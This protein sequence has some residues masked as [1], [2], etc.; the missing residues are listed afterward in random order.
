MC[1]L[2][3]L[4]EWLADHPVMLPAVLCVVLP[5]LSDAD[6]SAPAVSTLKRICRECKL[7]LYPHADDILASS[8][9]R[10]G[11]DPKKKKKVAVHFMHA[12][13]H[14]TNGDNR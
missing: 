11:L 14:I 6:L 4:A 13:G 8:Q 1:L 3:S 7:H 12:S 5:A 9:V 2:G 10:T